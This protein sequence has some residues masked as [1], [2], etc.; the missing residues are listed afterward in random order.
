MGMIE[1]ERSNGKIYIHTY[2]CVYMGVFDFQKN[3]I[4]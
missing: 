3:N 4:S 2:M 1:V